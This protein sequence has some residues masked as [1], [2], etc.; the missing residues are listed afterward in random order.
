M[1][2]NNFMQPDNMNLAEPTQRL[3]EVK[4]VT[5]SWVA[6][7]LGAAEE[8]RAALVDSLR[9]HDDAASVSRPFS[10]SAKRPQQAASICGSCPLISTWALA[11]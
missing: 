4:P 11:A 6:P 9:D 5:D 1:P 3:D 2:D 8:Q 10:I 7:K